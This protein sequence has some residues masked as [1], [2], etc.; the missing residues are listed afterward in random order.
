MRTLPDVAEIN[1]RRFSDSISDDS[2]VS[3]VP[4]KSVQEETGR[5]VAD[6]TKRWSE[7]KKGYTPFQEGGVL[8]AK[9]PPCMEN[10]KYALA[11]DLHGGRAAGSTEFHVFRPK[12]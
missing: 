8:F 5:L 3:F 11:S 7:G 1:P 6:Q 9:I 4:M 12:P 10:G 2:L